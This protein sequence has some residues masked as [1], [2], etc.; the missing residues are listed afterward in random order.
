MIEKSTRPVTRFALA[1]ALTLAAMHQLPAAALADDL[2]ISGE[3]D[4]DGGGEG[5]DGDEGSDDGIVSTSS[6][7]E[8][9][10]SREFSRC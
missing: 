1:I 9:G 8:C 5:L 6:G 2:P 4:T 3:G 7:D 10:G